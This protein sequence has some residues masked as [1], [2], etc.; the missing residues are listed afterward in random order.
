MKRFASLII[1]SSFVFIWAS[2]FIPQSIIT[3]YTARNA[4]ST[5]V[6]KFTT[7]GVWVPTVQSNAA[8]EK[9]A[10]TFGN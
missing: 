2:A 7:A 9:F 6:N 3:K 4:D 8:Q 1:G 10:K 5:F